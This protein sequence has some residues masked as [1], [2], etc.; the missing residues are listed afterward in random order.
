MYAV[1]Q[2]HPCAQ[3]GGRAARGLRDGDTTDRPPAA[4]GRTSVQD[5][6]WL[7]PIMLTSV[8]RGS[9]DD[10]YP[11]FFTGPAGWSSALPDELEVVDAE[12]RSVLEHL[13][14]IRQPVVRDPLV[15]LLECDL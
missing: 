2:Q 14:A 4:T 15:P 7:P 5:R 11:N 10:C 13:V 3:R 8:G 12:H 1:P 6:D 9:S